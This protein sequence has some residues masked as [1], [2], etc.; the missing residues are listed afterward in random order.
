MLGESHSMLFLVLFF[1]I[2]HVCTHLSMATCVGRIVCSISYVMPHHEQTMLAD[3]Q[4]V[5][6]NRLS[7]CL[8]WFF[9]KKQRGVLNEH[10]FLIAS[11]YGQCMYFFEEIVF[12][13]I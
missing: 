4:P 6:V 11:F 5:Y 3:L 7:T 12:M 2:A 9:R 1:N 10:T 8:V 13:N